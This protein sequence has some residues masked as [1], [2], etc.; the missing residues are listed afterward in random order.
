M[1]TWKRVS[2]QFYNLQK[3]QLLCNK[4]LKPEALLGHTTRLLVFSVGQLAEKLGY[5][6]PPTL[7]VKYKYLNF[8]NFLA[9]VT[10]WG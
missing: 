8:E 1:Q 5:A 2:I 9:Q 10:N 6:R 3:H 7:V 4:T